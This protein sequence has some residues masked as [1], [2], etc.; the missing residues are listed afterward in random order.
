MNWTRML[1]LAAPLALAVTLAG[2]LRAE[3]ADRFAVISIANE[4]NANITVVYRWADDPN[5]KKKH[6]FRPGTQTWFSHQ[7]SRPDEDR[8]P[9]FYLAFDADTTGQMYQEEKRLHGFRAP[10]QSYELG[11]KYVFKYNGPSKRFI[12]IYDRDKR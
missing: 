1:A 2:S 9:D 5:N 3:A 12:E 6:L 4:T 7:Y 11:H 8:S 10:D